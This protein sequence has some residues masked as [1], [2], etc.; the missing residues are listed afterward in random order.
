LS[1]NGRNSIVNISKISHEVYLSLHIWKEHVEIDQIMNIHEKIIWQSLLYRIPLINQTTIWFWPESLMLF[2]SFLWWC[3]IHLS[4]T[5]ALKKAY[6]QLKVR[7]W[8]EI[9]STLDYPRNSRVSSSINKMKR[10]TN[11][12]IWTVLK[13]N[14]KIIETETQSIP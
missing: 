9:Y 7:K 4:N 8:T 5:T 12:T 10:K 6:F 14:T 13:S 1:K 3:S 11:Q 2:Y